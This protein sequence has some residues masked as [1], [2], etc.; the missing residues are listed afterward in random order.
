[1]LRMTEKQ[2]GNHN[3][4]D[5]EIATGALE[6]IPQISFT[7]LGRKLLLLNHTLLGFWGREVGLLYKGKLNSK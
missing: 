3:S 2:R 1:M 6:F 4:D 5:L 7:S